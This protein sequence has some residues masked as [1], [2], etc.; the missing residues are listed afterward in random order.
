M[1]T[2]AMYLPQY[3]TIPEN[4]KWWGNG[5]TEWVAVKE[6]EPL[7]EDHIQPKIPMNHYYYDLLDRSTMK[8][9][10]RWIHQYEVDGLCFYHY[11]FENK[12][13]VLEKPAENLLKWKDINI[14]FC[15]CW[16]NE[17]WARTWSK[18]SNKNWWT[19][20]FE[21]T[22]TSEDPGILLHQK[23]GREMEWKA[24]F[25]YL[26]PFF[27]DERY[28]KKEGK[29]LFLFYKPDEISCLTKMT[30]YWRKLAKEHNFDL[31]FIGLNTTNIRGLDAILLNAPAMFIQEDFQRNS[32]GLRFYNYKNIWNNILAAEPIKAG[33]TYVGGFVNFDNTPR[34]GK[35]G[36]VVKKFSLFDFKNYMMQLA[37]KNYE[38][39]NEYLFINAWNEWGEGMYLEPDEQFGFGYLEALR[40]AKKTA[41]IM[42]GKSIENGNKD[43]IHYKRDLNHNK[44]LKKQKKMVECLNRWMTLKENDISLST[45][46]VKLG[47]RKVAIYGMGI[48]GK[49]LLT[50][51]ESHGI[52]V[53]YIIDRRTEMKYP[54]KVIKSSDSKME[55]V[56]AIIVT[57]VTE[58]EE[59]YDNLK[60]KIDYPI[61][62]LEELLCV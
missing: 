17:S 35:S 4:D 26:L 32:Q 43:R 56:D 53:A 50:E 55:K 9:Q 27:Q 44:E 51:L 6:A 3:H 11:Y 42:K 62:S 41:E 40:E 38:W 8:I 24:H 54:G 59:I 57:P 7:F 49:H 18:L 16:A 14:P 19:D 23:Y 61:L 20:K 29:P 28:L 33:S 25:E 21:T 12:K 22:M 45:Y 52:I 36:A 46:L 47:F 5:F 58:F 15:F 1:K 13:M 60:N 34:R 30:E 10:E 31:Y 48:L 37:I 2:I 39:G